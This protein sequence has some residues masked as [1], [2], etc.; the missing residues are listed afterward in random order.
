M[1]LTVVVVSLAQV[2]LA[3]A[4]RPAP[5]PGSVASHGPT[6]APLHQ[7]S[8]IKVRSKDGT[9]IAVECAGSGPSLLIVH[10]GTGDRKRWQPYLSRFAPRF[11]VCAMDRR[12]HG[13]S[14]PG[15]NYR[16]QKEFEDV[17]A[18]AKALPGPVAVL[19]HS[20]GGVCA[21]EAARLTKKITRLVLYEPPVR[22]PDRTA[23]ADSMARLIRKGQR[24]AA[25]ILFLQRAPQLTSSEIAAMQAQPLWAARVAG[26]DIQV[27]EL[28]ALSKYHFDPAR[29][30]AL[31]V[32][33][34]L[35]TGNSTTSPDLKL[36]TKTLLDVLP[37]VSLYVFAGQGHNAMD[38]VP[39]EFTAATMNF[40]Q[41]AANRSGEDR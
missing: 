1:F 6:G 33:T 10:G 12:G 34:L 38:N 15:S 8:I 4:N 20:L 32:P 25:L 41:R 29:F 24:E 40:L 39:D 7:N 16:L 17:A 27:R 19:G 22:D 2:V 35:L 30:T 13:E 18:V 5:A 3:G 36:A 14:A 28:R 21:L 37:Q 26:V 11:S 23:V 9:T 31:N